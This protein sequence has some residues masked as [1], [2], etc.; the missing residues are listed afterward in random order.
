MIILYRQENNIIAM[1]N[2]SKEFSIDEA[3]KQVPSAAEYR[4]VESSNLP[5]DKYLNT[6]SDALVVDFS[7][8]GNEGIDF[9]II[10]AREITKQRLRRE[11]ISAFQENDVV[12]RDAYL[13]ND[14]IKLSIAIDERDRL[15]DLPTKVDIIS[16]I[17][18]L[19]NIH[20]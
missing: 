13:E 17:D 10:K 20:P 5:N 3:I 2:P 19:L 7:K 11:R 6:F 9:D 4:I 1:L 15:R 14:Q 18:Q 12:I 8:T 16:D